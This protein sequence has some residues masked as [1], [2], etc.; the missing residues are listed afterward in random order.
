MT[1][2]GLTIKKKTQLMHPAQS[3]RRGALQPI[4]LKID[5]H[6]WPPCGDSTEERLSPPRG[7]GGKGEGGGAG[8]KLRVVTRSV[9]AGLRRSPS[10][11]TQTID[12]TPMLLSRCKEDLKRKRDEVAKA[13]EEVKGFFSFC[14]AVNLEK[15]CRKNG[16][17]ICS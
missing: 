13:Y 3:P 12:G 9:I 6:S 2:V 14:L 8:E 15:K 11:R 4:P 5:V 16:V 10:L 1:D 7:E 17:G